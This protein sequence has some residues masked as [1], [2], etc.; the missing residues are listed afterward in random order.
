M[1]QLNNMPH[2]KTNIMS[3]AN[4]RHCRCRHHRRHLRRKGWRHG[5]T[6][7]E[8]VQDH[9]CAPQLQMGSTSRWKGHRSNGTP[10]PDPTHLPGDRAL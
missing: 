6:L 9:G 3:T 5:P 1:D 7:P 10:S 8:Q 4:Q 2:N